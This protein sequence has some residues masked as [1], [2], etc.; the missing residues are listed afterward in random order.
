[1]VNDVRGRISELLAKAIDQHALDQAAP[2][3]ELELVRQ[4]LASYGELGP[5]GRL[6]CPRAA[7]GYAAEG[8]GYAAAPVPLPPLGWRDLSRPGAR[9]A[10]HDRAPLYASSISRTC[11]RRWSSRSAAWIASPR[12]S[13]AGESRS[14]RLNAPVS[15]I[16]RVGGR[17]R[18]EHGPGRQMIEARFLRLLAADAEPARKSPPISR[19]PS[20]PAPL[21]HYL[22]ERQGRVRKSALLG[23]RGI[24]LRRPRLDRPAERER[25]L[26][27][28]G[29]PATAGACWSPSYCG[30][31]TNRRNPQ[32]FADLSHEDR[33]RI[34]RES[35][36]RSI[37]AIA[38]KG[39]KG[40]R[41]WPTDERHRRTSGDRQSDAAPACL[42][43]AAQARG[44]IVFAGEHLSYQ[45]TWQEG[46]V[47]SAHE[48]LKRL[49]AMAVH[50]E[51][52]A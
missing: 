28:E 6:S 41:A 34:C 8:G 45:P 32:A 30:G 26:S 23:E 47:L 9:R 24:D 36:R 15:A 31:W 29:F 7:R 20:K 12:R 11:R 3:G 19:P 48:A 17:V 13:T 10:R 33:F 16:R 22:A 46:A 1:M 52:A 2:R 44:P 21:V 5:D 40:M 37:P 35:S 18:I 25:R 39:W 27:L 50:R 38:A 49:H 43:R 51:A 42:R 4:L 14:V